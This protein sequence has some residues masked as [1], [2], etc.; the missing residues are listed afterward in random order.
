MLTN[1]LR[2]NG[3]AGRRNSA[4]NDPA[5]RE[6]F[7]LGLLFR[8]RSF[9]LAT[10]RGRGI[11]L[12]RVRYPHIIGL[13]LI[14]MDWPCR[15]RRWAARPI[16]GICGRRRLCGGRY[17]SLHR[18]CDAR[19]CGQSGVPLAAWELESYINGVHIFNVPQPWLFPLFRGPH[20][21]LRD[22]AIGSLFT[23]GLGAPEGN[24]R[25]GFG[26][27]RWNRVDCDG[28][29]SMRAPATLCGL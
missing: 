3:S 6:I 22:L 19:K 1:K 10:Q 15:M 28:A 4:H 26:W 13:S 18:S 25:N 14:M 7:L 8:C 27:C 29:L 20:S 16:P 11:D 23:I 9:F 12:F 21:H 2:Q 5:R 24:F 17:R